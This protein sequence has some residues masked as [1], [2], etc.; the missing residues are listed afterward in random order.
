MMQKRNYQE[1]YDAVKLLF[2]CFMA[3]YAV[4]RE[5]MPLHWL[6]ASQVVSAGIFLCGFGL[7]LAGWFLSGT[8]FADR[9]TDALALFAVLTAASCLVNLRYGYADNVKALGAMALFFF[10]FFD[11]GVGKTKEQRRRE[12]DRITG[13]VN[14]VWAFFTLASFLMFT[15]S[16]YYKVDNGGW[17]AT[18]QG[19]FPKYNRL[20]G[21]FQDPNYAGYV[22]VVVILSSL[23]FIVN[24]K[25]RGVKA[26][27]AANILLQLGFLTLAGSFSANLI[28]LA[29]VCVSVFYAAT[30]KGRKKNAGAFV[31]N[32]VVAALC[33]AL[34]YGVLIG[35]QYVL[36]Y[37]RSVNELLPE[38]IPAA[39]TDIYHEVYLHSDLEILKIKC[40]YGKN[41][42]K[43]ETDNGPIKR[44]DTAEAKGED[45]VS[46]GRFDR[47]GQT[48]KI[49]AKTPVFGTS[50][51]NL[52]SYAKAHFPDTLMAKYKMAPH[53]GYLDILAGTG[54]L[55]MAAFLLFFLPALIALLKKYFRFEND[56]DFL[57]SAVTVFVFAVSAMFVS[58]LFFM[59]SI[60]AFLFWTFFGY[61]LHSDGDAPGK[62]GLL[63]KLY[64]AVF[65]R[66]EKTA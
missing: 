66:K 22:S 36:P 26:I 1:K 6:I 7:I 27:N 64:E 43:E 55:G 4:V 63:M 52:S 56:T 51:R 59:I 41:G 2:L 25:K 57:F 16:V 15:L 53:N 3:V 29:A 47:W 18:N 61:A 54:V 28:L 9:R 12:I 5:V 19:F 10:L 23:R 58:D 65:R 24:T 14:T 50:P 32:A 35:G 46:H 39:V 34:C 38:S 49:F 21:V 8:C 44:K 42:E 62:K 48:L 30:S 37:F 17:V 33:G 60:G 13:T 20:W 11:A 40:A 31:R 45:D